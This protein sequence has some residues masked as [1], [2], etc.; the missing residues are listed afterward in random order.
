M[1]ALVA[2]L[3]LLAVPAAAGPAAPADDTLAAVQAVLDVRTG[4]V[5]AKDRAAFLATVDPEASAAFVQAQAR[6][7]DGLAALPLA[8]FELRAHIDDSGDL[9]NAAAGRYG[10]ARVFLPET[11][12]RYRFEGYD[13]TDAVDYLWL[14]FVERDGAWFV[15]GDED[16][17]ALGLDTDRS[18]WDLG[19]V[20]IDGVAHFLVLSDPADAARATA[21]AALAEQA[22]ARMS[23]VWDQPWPGRVPLVLPPSVE[24]LERL[25]QSTVDLDKFVAFASYGLLED[26]GPDGYS[27]SSPRIFVQDERLARTSPASQ[28]E[29]LVHELVHA[30]AAPLAG[31]FIPLWVH[32]GVADWAATGR[33][34][35]VAAPS[36]S[37]GRLP[38]PYE[39]TTGSAMS[40]QR[41]Y[42]ESRSAISFLAERSGPGAPSA[43][44]R[45]LGK[46]RT[47]PG[48]VD[49]HLDAALRRVT[50]LGLVEFEQAW[51]ADR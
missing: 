34:A 13:A 10:K 41:S 28:V 3:V 18:L 27:A 33:P 44:F 29:T 31:P 5:R 51:A 39:L 48:S 38:R 45:E 24:A 6:Q 50:G 35:A 1:P 46:V 20:R 32:E 12:Q 7:F 17:S 47:E 43:L 21:L 30:A 37:D 42:K 49:H 4:A 22:A 16:L 19:P 8:S 15:G 26:E 36:G 23:E 11:R 14:S 2:A 25:L 9:A 40:I